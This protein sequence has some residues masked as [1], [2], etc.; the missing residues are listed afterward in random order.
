M[1]LLAA[2][3]VCTH[4]TQWTV[5]WQGGDGGWRVAFTMRWLTNAQHFFAERKWDRARGL[6]LPTKAIVD[7]VR[8]ES[9]K[10]GLC[11]EGGG[12]DATQTS[13]LSLVDQYLQKA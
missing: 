9:A 12:R 8:R 5:K 4:G 2:D 7:A 10:A 1:P 11:D 6:A 13:L 3:I